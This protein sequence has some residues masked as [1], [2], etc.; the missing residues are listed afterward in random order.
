M[1]IRPGGK[2]LITAPTAE[3]PAFGYKNVAL[4]VFGG[5]ALDLRQM[6]APKLFPDTLSGLIYAPKS[7]ATIQ[8]SLAVEI[9]TGGC[10]QLFAGNVVLNSSPTLPFKPCAATGAGSNDGKV[11]IVR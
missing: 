1:D 9:P 3:L 8:D 6:T 11:A 2:V 4:V 10:L 5:G 7:T